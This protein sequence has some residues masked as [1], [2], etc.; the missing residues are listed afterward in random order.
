M[1]GPDWLSDGIV[2]CDSPLPTMP[3]ECR[4]KIQASYPEKT[5]GLVMTAGLPS[6]GQLMKCGNF[7][8]LHRLLAVTAKVLKFRWLLL[9]KVRKDAPTPSTDDLNKAETL[10]I[11]EVQK[12]LVKNDNFPRDDDNVWRCRGRIQNANVF[13]ST[14]HPVLLLRT[15][16]L[17]TLFVQSAHKSHAWRSQGNFD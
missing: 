8:S 5:V 6:I 10:W 1:N 3:D 2:I 4:T 9:T 14:K 11:I 7:S 16:F 15:H 13:F 17:T 12:E